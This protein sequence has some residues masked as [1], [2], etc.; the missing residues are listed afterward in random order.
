MRPNWLD[1]NPRSAIQ[2]ERTGM[3][4]APAEAGTLQVT[5][6]VLTFKRTD[7][8]A[9]LLPQLT[10]QAAQLDADGTTATSVLIVDNDPA[11]SAAAA[12][13]S[14]GS[15]VLYV[16]ETTP[17]IAAARARAVTE[18][19]AADLLIFIDDDEWPTR[20][21][22]A[23][24]V[25]TWRDHGQPAGVVGRVSPTYDGEMDPW[26]KAGGF[27]TRR[28]YATGTPVPAA[29]SANLLLD[30]AVLR[31]RGLN[32][33]T[34][35]GLRGGEDTK[36]TR[37]L[38]RAGE[39]LV[40]CNEAEVIDVIPPARMDWRW[41]LRR[42]FSHG[43]VTSRIEIGFGNLPSLIR[44]K[45]AMLALARLLTGLTQATVGWIRRDL[46]P[47]ARGARLMYR[48]AG[49]LV[50]ALGRDVIEYRRSQGS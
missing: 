3:S 24:M 15:P 22:L 25:R 20:G 19:A 50:G 27:F 7:A 10:A 26:I 17:G 46:V 33:D 43:A 31:A 42:A 29:S 28:Q 35:L 44:V 45:L 14:A 5:I 48:G 41:V 11:G 21:W 34:R 18:S 6:G 8:L 38:A 30:L 12:A 2:R 39:R 37:T 9:R 36:L 4:D 13:A 47:Q 23:A 1:H 16:Q 32:F 40:W 49:M